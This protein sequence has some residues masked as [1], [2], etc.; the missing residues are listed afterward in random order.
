[1]SI[2]RYDHDHYDGA[3]MARLSY[4]EYVLAREITQGMGQRR[5]C[6]G[7]VAVVFPCISSHG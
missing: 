1:M 4:G 3:P 7:M 5:C 2:Q 6:Q